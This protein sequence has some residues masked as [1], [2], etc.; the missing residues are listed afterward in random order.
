MKRVSWVG[1]GLVTIGASMGTAA[2]GVDPDPLEKPA[3][4]VNDAATTS[5]GSQQVAGRIA[6]ELN[7]TCQCTSFS[8][9]SVTA[10]R[11]QTGWGWGEIL[12]AD[13]LAQAVSKQSNVS[14]ASALTQ[15]SASRQQGQGW[16]EIAR[17]RGVN[18]GDLVSSVEKSANAVAAA[19]KNADKA[20]QGSSSPAAAGRG[21]GHGSTG[22]GH[23]G[24]AAGG[25]G[26]GNGSGG[27]NS[28]GGNGGGGGGG[29]GGGGGKGH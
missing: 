17:A 12:I 18:L 21:A 3:A 6:A 1:I 2:W 20:P 5:A 7:S 13:R 9:A 8:A 15:V 4:T 29:N 28:G 24:G 11:A 19:A 10:Q 26:G 22:E 14:F 25:G 27:G 16:G 23:A